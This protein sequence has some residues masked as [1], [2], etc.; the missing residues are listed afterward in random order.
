MAASSSASSCLRKM[1]YL[2]LSTYL[3]VMSVTPGPNNIM[4][5]ASGANFGYRATVPHMLGIVL[6]TGVQ[7]LLCCLGLGI[8]FVTIPLLH[9]LLTWGGLAYMLYLAWKL[10]GMHAHG[11]KQAAKPITVLQAALF[12]WVNPKAWIISIT[13]ASVFLPHTDNIMHPTLIILLFDAVLCF[14]ST[15]IWACFGSAMRI[16]LRSGAYE[17][18][19][20]AIMALLLVIT[21]VLVVLK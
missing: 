4:V 7:A 3:F 6:G 1:D 10:L 21:A 11:D 18:A 12:Q 15:S 13:L 16:L 5:T 9:T 8:V 2:A 20:N 17:K 14:I 19:F